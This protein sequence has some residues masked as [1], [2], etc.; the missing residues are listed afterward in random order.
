[1]DAKKGSEAVVR[2]WEEEGGWWEVK[3]WEEEGRSLVSRRLGKGVRWWRWGR[4]RERGREGE[5]RDILG[6]WVVWV[7]RKEG[8]WVKRVFIIS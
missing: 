3:R 6:G 1:M 8:G 2:R 7:V 4:E 5:S